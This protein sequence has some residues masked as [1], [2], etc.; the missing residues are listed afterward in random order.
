MTEPCGSLADELAISDVEHDALVTTLAF[1]FAQGE[2]QSG[3]TIT[4]RTED[5]QVGATLVYGRDGDLA[6]V[7]RGPG[8]TDEMLNEL[9]ERLVLASHSETVVW[10]DV[11]FNVRPVEG[12]WRNRDDWQIVP[13]PPQAPRPDL[14]LG[15]HPFIVEIR[16][17]RYPD[18]AMLTATTQDRRAWELLLI[19][20]LVALGRVSRIGPRHHGHVWAFVGDELPPDTRY[21]QPGYSIPDWIYQS[22]DFTPTDDMDPL[23]EVP[24]DEYRSRRGV[25]PGDVFEI[26]DILR[27]L[28]NH[29]HLVGP[30][31]R[32]RSFAP[33]TGTSD[34][35][36]PGRCPSPW[37]TSQLSSRSRPS[38]RRERP[39]FV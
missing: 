37:A 31:T 18:Q 8:L 5:G 10:R 26:P 13:A 33:A 35:R 22:E 6:D 17:P 25:G 21:V 12:F 27:P 2:W 36:L 15:D 30:E 7:E 14:L 24:D 1:F 29:Y 9:R 39:T 19:L 3:R 38:C 28:L 16:L 34:L 11:F 4:Y 32:D 23:R 20:N